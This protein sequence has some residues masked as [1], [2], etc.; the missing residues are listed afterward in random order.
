LLRPVPE[1][2]DHTRSERRKALFNDLTCQVEEVVLN[3]LINTPPIESISEVSRTGPATEQH[4]IDSNDNCN[5]GNADAFEAASSVIPSRYYQVLADLYVSHP[6]RA[7]E[8]LQIGVP[9]LWNNVHFQVTFA[10]L[11]YQWLFEHCYD[12][13]ERGFKF[14]A[15]L[16]KGTHKLFW[17]DLEN[18]TRRFTAIHTHFTHI[19]LDAPHWRGVLHRKYAELFDLVSKFYF[20]YRDTLGLEESL[21]RAQQ[22]MDEHASSLDLPASHPKINTLNMFANEVVRTMRLIKNEAALI[23]YI[24]CCGHFRGGGDDLLPVASGASLASTSKALQDLVVS[25]RKTKLR[26]YSLLLDLSTPGYPMYP[27]RDVKAAAQSTLRTLFPTPLPAWLIHFLFRLLRPL[28]FVTWLE[29]RVTQIWLLFITILTWIVA[30]VVPSWITTRY[31]AA[32]ADH[33]YQQPPPASS[34]TEIPH[35]F[36]SNSNAGGGVHNFRQRVTSF[37]SGILAK[38]KRTTLSYPSDM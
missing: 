19:L 35:T 37:V 2:T 29:L 13:T 36:N 26:L 4:D 20:Y 14:F 10:L 18:G 7:Y 11:F 5:K 16:I 25:G 28:S 1:E 6:D 3:K 33:Q 9:Q 24:R 22:L 23:Q 31:S 27:T 8:L 21:V 12:D 17:L 38:H 30:N 32:K 15:M 34:S